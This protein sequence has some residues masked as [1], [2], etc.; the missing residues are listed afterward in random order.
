M[1]PEWK[2]FHKFLSEFCVSPT[3]H[4][5]WPNLA[6]IGRCEVAEKSSGIAY[7]KDASGTLF[8]PPFRPHLANRAQDLVNVVGPWPGHVYRLW[9]G[10]AMV[11]RTY[12][13]KC[14]K[15]AIQYRLSAYKKMMSYT[16]NLAVCPITGC[17]HWEDLMARMILRIVQHSPS[18]LMITVTAFLW[19]YK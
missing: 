12:S 1:T 13:G 11:C 18:I 7:K 9:S 5:S 10:S 4:V 19:C 2:L 15:I 3:I 8:S 14:P 17:C 16:A 6:K